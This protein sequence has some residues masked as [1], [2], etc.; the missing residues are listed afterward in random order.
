MADTASLLSKPVLG[1][2]WKKS[3]QSHPSLVWSVH[4][5]STYEIKVLSQLQPRRNADVN[6][7]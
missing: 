7:E 6:Y 4:I 1:Q 5:L 2:T 3:D